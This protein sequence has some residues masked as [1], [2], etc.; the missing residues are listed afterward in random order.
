[1]YN[2]QNFG[3]RAVNYLLN[4]MKGPVHVVLIG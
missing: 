2:E 3:T 4:I 1:M